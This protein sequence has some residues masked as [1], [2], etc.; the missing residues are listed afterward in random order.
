MGQGSRMVITGDLKQ[1]DRPD[2]NGL[3]DLLHKIKHHNRVV[4]DIKTIHFN[5]CD[6]E[7]SHIVSRVL[8][9]YSDKVEP[10][11]VDNDSIKHCEYSVFSKN[12]RRKNE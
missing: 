7:R 2:D 9:L 1:S 3:L 12:Y 10:N 4:P 8:Q 6:V 5:R 11:I